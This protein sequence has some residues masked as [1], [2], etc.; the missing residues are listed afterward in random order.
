MSEYYNRSTVYNYPGSIVRVRFQDCLEGNSDVARERD[1]VMR[2]SD[3]WA[4][5]AVV[6]KQMP[7]PIGD[8]PVTDD[9]DRAATL[10]RIDN[11]FRGPVPVPADSIRDAAMKKDRPR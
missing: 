6:A 11:W 5:A 8:A 4:L 3:W 10:R 1:I 9:E 7:I 2:L